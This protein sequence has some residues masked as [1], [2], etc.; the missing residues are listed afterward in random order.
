V[1]MKSMTSSTD[2]PPKRAHRS[3]GSARN[4][5]AAELLSFLKQTRAAAPWTERDLAKTLNIGMKEARQVLTVMQFEGYVTSA[6]APEKWRTT[7]QGELV[8]GS[9]APRFTR[10]SVDKALS[11]LT[12]GGC[13]PARGVNGCSSASRTGPDGDHSVRSAIVGSM[14]VA[15]TAGK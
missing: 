13:T 6:G 15:L 2:R 9:K 11:L 14:R 5:A 8:S 10:E 1:A 12:T 7:L 4:L 3:V